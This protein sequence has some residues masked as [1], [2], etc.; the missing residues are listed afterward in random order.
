MPQALA[1]ISVPFAEPCYFYRSANSLVQPRARH[2]PRAESG[3]RLD[4][5]RPARYSS[6]IMGTG[7]QHAIDHPHTT[8]QRVYIRPKLFTTSSH[9]EERHKQRS[10][11]PD[12][13]LLNARWIGDTD[14]LCNHIYYLAIVHSIVIRREMVVARSGG[15]SE[16]VVERS[17]GFRGVFRP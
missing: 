11:F 10:F 6:I 3:P 1:S 14:Y 8:P 16:I 9:E 4:F 17:G 15:F 5:V 12:I 13:T 7:P 2:G